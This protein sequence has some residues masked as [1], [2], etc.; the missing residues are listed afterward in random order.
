MFE[1]SE[2][3]DQLAGALAKAQGAF[4]AVPKSKTAR[5]QMKSGGEYSYKYADLADTWDIARAPLSENGL[6]VIQSPGQFE[7]G[8]LS[9]TTMLLHTSGQWVRSTLAIDAKDA[10]PQ[11]MGT[12]IT[13]ARRYGLA[14]VL[15]LVTDDDTDAQ[16]HQP[17]REQ[18]PAQ[19]RQGGNG[20]AAQPSGQQPAQNGASYSKEREALV[21]ALRTAYKEA[22]A[23]GA[24]V[25]PPSAPEVAG[26]SDEM[27]RQVITTFRAAKMEAEK[28][29]QAAE[30]DELDKAVAGAGK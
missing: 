23:A 3:L 7:R 9:V 2:Q 5:V 13:Y 18:R 26:W 28:G 6:S 24:D 1:H 21:T 29:H 22:R 16:D 17:G 8:V 27:V 10:T 30:Y 12:A 15:G 20:R 4:K 11:G 25:A 14:A 19:Q